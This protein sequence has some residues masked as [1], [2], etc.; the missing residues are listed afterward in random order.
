MSA[1]TSSGQL[2][3]LD[4]RRRVTLGKLAHHDRYTA[5]LMSNG[6]ILLEPAV[7]VTADEAA[8][9][10]TPEFIAMLQRRINDINNGA[11]VPV[12]LDELRAEL[13]ALDDIDND[14]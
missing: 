7:V 1:A 9:I 3:E 12:D 13:A 11:G 2:L 5:R 14:D 10:R 8:M 6:S 4:A